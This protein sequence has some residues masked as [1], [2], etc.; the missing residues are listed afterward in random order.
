M[1]RKLKKFLKTHKTAT[2]VGYFQH[3]VSHEH[4]LSSDSHF[5]IAVWAESL[6]NI[7][8]LRKL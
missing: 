4:Y 6:N 8:K 5:L 1:G 7:E 3:N 2:L